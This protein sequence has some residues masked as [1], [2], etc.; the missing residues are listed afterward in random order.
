[1][2]RI[3][4]DDTDALAQ[5]YDRHSSRAFRLASS[6]CGDTSQAE[7]AVEDGFQEIWRSRAS[8]E[9]APGCFVA[10]SMKIVKDRAFARSEPDAPLELLRRLPEAEAEVIVLAFYGELSHADIAAQ[11][12]LPAGTVTG[13]MR[14]GLEKLRELSP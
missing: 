13:R 5:L 4:A 14:L 9:P 3:S 11:L 10:W 8:Y 12:G 6:I 1:M 2:A 7:G